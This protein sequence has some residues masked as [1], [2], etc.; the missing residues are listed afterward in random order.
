[1]LDFDFFYFLFSFFKIFHKFYFVSL[2]MRNFKLF[3]R[4][5]KKFSNLE[6]KSC[7][8]YIQFRLVRVSEEIFMMFFFHVFWVAGMKRCIC[9]FLVF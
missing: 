9:G 4:K 2:K 6:L 1:M 8:V 7:V 5:F 3:D